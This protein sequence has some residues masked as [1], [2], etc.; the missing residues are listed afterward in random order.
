VPIASWT[1][2]D[3]EHWL[4][5]LDLSIWIEKFCHAN[6]I[7]GLTLLLMKEDDL[8]R[9]PLAITRLCDIKKLWYR[10]Q[11]LQNQEQDFYIQLNERIIKENHSSLAT[12]TQ[13]VHTNAHRL[14]I[15]QRM[16]EA[17]KSVFKTL[18]GEKFKT[19]VS[20]MYALCSG[21]WT[22]FIMVVVHNRVPNVQK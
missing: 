12:T 8:R 19:L 1:T 11:L 9:E 22:S 3:V 16:K 4:R 15:E 13:L 17:E 6:E 14:P 5:S 2:V 21:I 18:K 7:D 20:F 10:I